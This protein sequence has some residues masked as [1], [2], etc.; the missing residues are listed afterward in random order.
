[1]CECVSE[2]ETRRQRDAPPTLSSELL[3]RVR[4]K[5]S[6]S[7]APTKTAPPTP[8]LPPPGD[9]RR[10]AGCCLRKLP[11]KCGAMIWL[12]LPEELKRKRGCARFTPARPGR[13]AAPSGVLRTYRVSLVA[14]KASWRFLRSVPPH[15]EPDELLPA[16]ATVV[17]TGARRRARQSDGLRLL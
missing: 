10:A 4:E 5:A 7:A 6:L 12:Q 2:K 15:V 13:G 3:T 9:R 17:C 14:G 1:M 11:E 8:S 16:P